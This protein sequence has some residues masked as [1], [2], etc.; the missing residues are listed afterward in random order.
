MTQE[1]SSVAAEHTWD[2]K[3]LYA[4]LK[5]WESAFE[6]V[7][8]KF[9][10]DIQALKGK[11]GNGSIVVK[12]LFENTYALQKELMNLYTYAHLRH[13]EDIS[14]EDHKSAHD[15]ISA[16][17][18]KFSE[19]TSWIEPELLA[20]PAQKLEK[21][22]QCPELADYKMVI[23]KCVRLKPHT[24]S[25]REEELLALSGKAFESSEKAFGALNNADLKFPDVKDGKGKTHKLS[26]GLFQAH[27]RSTDRVLRENAFK[28]F[29]GAFLNFE[30]TLCEL[31][32]GKVQAHIFNAKARSYDSCLQ[33]ALFPH[34]IDTAVYDSLINATHRNI[35]QL[36]RFVSLRKKLMKL[37]AFH[38]YDFYA[39][40]TD[41]IEM[42]FDYDKAVDLTLEAVVPLGPSYCQVLKRGL[43]QERWV[44]IYENARK[45]S[46]AYSSGCY[47]S[48][49]YILLNYQGFLNDVM[50]LAHE[51]GHSMHTYF[52]NQSQPYHDSHYSIFVA[53]V[54]STFNEEL[55]FRHLLKNAKTKEERIYLL[56]Q[57]LDGIRATFFRQV[58]FAEFEKQI[59]ELAENGVPLTPAT[60]KKTYRELNA[61]Y[62]GPDFAN[63]AELDIE[64]ARV[65]HFYY[66]FYVYQYATGISAAFALVEQVLKEGPKRYLEFLSAGGSNY[67]V[68]VLRVAGV[69]M[70]TPAPVDALLHRFS[71]LM[72]ELEAEL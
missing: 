5:D 72:D 8:E 30:N 32:N 37:D 3:I 44:D 28:A 59:H 57:K 61:K 2:L 31:L 69:D 52:S 6:G 12:E 21:L 16:L 23:E 11:L 49:P 45:R 63:D 38:A 22:L 27:L 48:Y 46:G 17:L 58:L 1:R 15:R 55:L 14:Q 65:P 33:A 35:E 56:L 54:A 64:F 34:N 7:K 51:A 71:V 43:K 26:H 19:A 39:P 62:H 9:W 13:D 68:E 4:D 47:D 10:S 20:L 40:A 53:E 50:T 42:K 66:N 25:A 29:Q 36:H 70:C 41:D 67:P 24:L 60:L 18:Y